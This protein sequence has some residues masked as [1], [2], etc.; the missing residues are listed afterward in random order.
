MRTK[1]INPYIIGT[2]IGFYILSI[3][4]SFY[5]T[6]MFNFYEAGKLIG[7]LL[8]LKIIYTILDSKIKNVSSNVSCKNF[9]NFFA[10][11]ILIY[12]SVM[13]NIYLFEQFKPFFSAFFSM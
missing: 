2:P 8:V 4:F 3:L 9:I 12:F 13:L 11:A 7:V 5:N 10:G 6:G 1:E